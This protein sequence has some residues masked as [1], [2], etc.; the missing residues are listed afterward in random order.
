M[1]FL[2]PTKALIFRIVHVRNLPWI[3]DH[4]LHCP[5][6]SNQDPNYVSIGSASLIKK[7]AH[8]TVPIPP[9]GTLS[10]YVPFYFTPFSM[11]LYNIK[12]GHGGITRR[13]NEEIAIIV[14]SIYRVRELGL[15]FVFTNQHAYAV[16]TD[17]YSD[18]AELT[19]VDWP[20]LHGRD[21]KTDD[22]D[23]GKQLRYQAEALI[24][25]HVLLEAILGVA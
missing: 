11:M 1:M 7:R 12:T 9:G 15:P 4:G 13:A 2:N 17:F 24:H 25:R 20:L 6:S 21:F 23:P 3:V 22:R 19:K 8:R 16:D 14:S 5:N 10:E 18:V